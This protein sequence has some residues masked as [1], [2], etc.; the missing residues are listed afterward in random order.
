LVQTDIDGRQTHSQIERVYIP[1]AADVLKMMP[2]PVV[3]A[4]TIS[5]TMN[6]EGTAYKIFNQFG[7]LLQTGI[8]GSANIKT[9]DLPAGIYYFCVY[10]GAALIK[11]ASFIKMKE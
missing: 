4:F 8:I 3:N 2:Q 5:S 10:K 11:R 9:G 1:V 7:M 6:L